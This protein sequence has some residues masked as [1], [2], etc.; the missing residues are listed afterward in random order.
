MQELVSTGSVMTQ[1]TSPCASAASSAG[2]IVELDDLA[3]L[4]AG[5]G[6]RPARPGRLT[7]LPVDQPHERLV[8]RAVI[9]AV[10]HQD[11]RP[12]GHGARHA[13]REAV[14]VGGGGRDLPERQAEALPQAVARRPAR[15]RSAA[16]RSGRGRPGGGWRAPPAAAN[17]RTSSRCRRGRNRRAVLPSMSVMRGALGAARPGSGTASASRASS[18]SARRR[19]SRATP[20]PTVALRLRP[21]LGERPRSRFRAARCGHVDAAVR[22]LR[23]RSDLR[24]LVCASATAT[25]AASPGIP[26]HWLQR[27][28]PASSGTLVTRSRHTATGFATSDQGRR[29]G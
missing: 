19:R 16:Y 26:M 11:L 22:R 8:D 21:R 29:G 14:G 28:K 17:G 25:L 3:R 24:R 15:P 12:P 9:A 2:E 27:M 6:T 23:R 1:A 4:R 13:Q 7:G 18:A 10:E 5:R 20:L